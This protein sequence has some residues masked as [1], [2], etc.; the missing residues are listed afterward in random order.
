MKQ[1]GVLS[2]KNIY[3]LGAII[4]LYTLV[5]FFIV[6]VIAKKV[7]TNSLSKALDREVVI[8]KVAVNPFTLTAGIEVITIKGKNN[9]VL[10][11]TQKIFTNVSWSSLFT[12][13]GVVSE[14][15]LEN[16]YV[17][18]IRNKDG[19]Y[20]FS[21]LI[22]PEEKDNE[23]LNKEDN[24][25]QLPKFVLK[26]T[27]I[28]GG[29][30]QV[31][32]QAANVTHLVNDVTLSLPFLSSKMKNRYE[33]TL[34]DIGFVLNQ[35]AVDI[36]VE[37][38]PFAEDLSTQIDVKT[39]DID[40]IHY[41]SYLV[42]PETLQI[43]G[44]DLS[45]DVHGDYRQ[46]SKD[47]LFVLKGQVNLLNVDIKGDDKDIL[48]IP[49]LKLDINPSNV[50]AGHMDLSTLLIAKPEINLSRDKEGYLDVLTHFPTPEGNSQAK[51]NEKTKTTDSK[52]PFTL[53]LEKFEI[54]DGLV[55]FQ[56]MSNEKP[57]TSRIYPVNIGIADLK[58]KDG[59][60]G[61]YR[62]S[63]KTEGDESLSSQG[64]FLTGPLKIDGRLDLSNLLF[65]KYLPYYEDFVTIDIKD[66]TLGLSTGFD[67]AQ[68][69]SKLNMVFNSEELS[70]G[71]L[72]IS[73]SLSKDE[74]IN[75]PDFKI[76][77]SVIDLGNKKIVIGGISAENGKLL[78]KRLTDGQMNF[79]NIIRTG[80]KNQTSESTVVENSAEPSK[81]GALPWG[82]RL[83]GFGATGFNVKF[84]DLTNKDPVTIDLSD[85]SINADDLQTFDDKNGS[86]AVKMN[87]NKNGQIRIKGKLNPSSVSSVLDLNLEKID[88]KSLQ[89]Y[90]S[91]AVKI[92]VTEG[93]FNTNGKL[94]MNKAANSKM[95]IAFEGESSVTN[96]I[97]LDKQTAKDFFKCKSLYF[98][99]LDVSV[100]PVNLKVK[101]ISLTD[102]YSRVIVSE[103]GETNLNTIFKKETHPDPEDQTG[104]K[105]AKE[106]SEPPRIHVDNVTLQAG[107]ISF[108][109]YLTRPQ[110][111][112]DMK[113]I[114]GALTGLSS[115]E[116][117][118]AQLHLQGVHGQSSPLDIIGTINPLAKKKFAD[119][120]ISFKDIEL[121]NFT[122]YSS[123]YLGYKIEK[124]KLILDLEYM[125]DGNTLT[126]ANRVRFDNFTLG[127]RVQSDQA[128]SLPIGLAIS[129]LKNREGQIDLDLPVKGE[130]DDPE[131][132]VGAIVL[133]MLANLILKVVT[134]PFS[135]IGSMFG[136][137]EELGYVEFAYGESKID[138]ENFDKI[139]KLSE[140]LHEKTSVSLEIQ[141][142]YDKLRD[143]E[144]LTVKGFNDLIKAEK[145]KEMVAQG[146]A[147]TTLEEVSV[148][149]DE[150]EQ[151]ID[152]AF[153][154]A[155]FPKPRD[156]AGVEKILEIEEKKTLLMTHIKI[157]QENL[158]LLAMERSENIKEYILETG[159]VEK[160]RIFLLEPD[161]SDGSES[162]KTSTVKFSLK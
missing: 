56:D 161:T 118:R 127:E 51:E 134:S 30:I 9:D 49:S 73:E 32:D 69:D 50:I 15:L 150:L 141:G 26:N 135:I 6:P 70:I 153:N 138:E 63:V 35:A 89:P 137:G 115:D 142:M 126:S 147:I 144:G 122:P 145:L 162:E 1:T 129:L 149:S 148:S 25:N 99:G 91:D 59:I 54:K 130:L 22:K 52:A 4:L 132:K 3:I 124:G 110:F 86:V 76:K 85:I 61:E 45:L 13:T 48:K 92:L 156:D 77:D 58:V 21:D 55:S 152:L 117:S 53:N 139:D 39:A 133:K 100:F 28:K 90:F 87:W 31:V 20:N 38:T 64:Q 136:G 7:L 18:I 80:Q 37:S 67:I 103:A 97:S 96:F 159:L 95:E 120:D 33:K 24:D 102:F 105:P 72:V 119:I 112:A 23:T 121:T 40:L 43:K 143:A 46:N 65:N 17:N 60:S 123:K 74:I 160:E 104:S 113:D 11:S 125:I 78:I 47:P 71:S 116:N 107:N 62:L 44:L 84:N 108:S 131:F 83:A 75:I 10:F 12:F 41:L 29:K 158:R 106:P 14:I 109:D 98:S 68:D 2:R 88:I 5:G 79:S 151:Y 27:I 16:P 57:F 8:E 101:D 93:D 128:T 146:S 111:T 42:L 114:A 157:G 19:T 34:M 81:T 82:I 66:G 36:H 140:I 94:R 155:Q 154:N